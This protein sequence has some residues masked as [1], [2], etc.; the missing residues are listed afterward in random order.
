MP[1]RF[2]V[3]GP[4]KIGAVRLEEAEAHHLIHV[5][6]IGAGQSVTLFDGRGTEA[7]AEVRGTTEGE[8]ELNV[9]ELHAVNTES[10]ID[11][12]LAA[13]VPKGGRF[14][15][16]IEKAT[17]LGVRRL[18]PLATHRS[19]VNPGETKLEKMRRTIVEASKQCGRSRL[20]ELASPMSW[21]DFVEHELSAGQCWVVD[22]AGEPFQTS[23]ISA[24]GPVVV[25][26]GPEGGFTDDE[27]EVAARAGAGL[28]SLGPRI[29]RI[30]TAA[31]AVAALVINGR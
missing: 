24:A 7:R 3:P 10:D 5:L 1:R 6:R 30:E 20:M 9:G 4:L 13:A 18:V 17:E 12:T 27:L 31:L 23:A 16:L 28:V 25:A 26:I 14:D 21:P 29:L 22:P 11:L 8:V 19:V 2:F 15:W